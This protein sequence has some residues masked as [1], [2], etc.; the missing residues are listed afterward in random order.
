M[1]TKGARRTHNVL[2]LEE[3]QVLAKF[4]A[5]LEKWHQRGRPIAEAARAAERLSAQDLQI[6]INTRS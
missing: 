1:T 5:S 2:S 3:P 6:R 4:K